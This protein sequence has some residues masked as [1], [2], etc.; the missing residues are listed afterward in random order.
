MK[1]KKLDWD[2]WDKGLVQNR[3]PTLYEC[4]EGEKGWT[5]WLVDSYILE[6]GEFTLEEAKAICQ[7]HYEKIVLSGLETEDED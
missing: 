7:E 1:V 4:V 3:K 6:H 5:P 2:S